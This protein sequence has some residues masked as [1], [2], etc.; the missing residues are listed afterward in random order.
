MVLTSRN[1]HYLISTMYR[2]VAFFL[3][4]AT[5]FFT[6]R[7]TA[8]CASGT[9]SGKIFTDTNRDG[10]DNESGAGVSG[11]TVYLFEPNNNVPFASTQ[12]NALGVY[13]FGA[14]TAAK[15]RVEFGVP[16]FGPGMVVTYAGTQNNTSVT[17]VPPGSCNVNMGVINSALMP[18]NALLEIGN[19]VWIDADKDGVQDADEL[20][21][22]GIKVGLY[23]TAGVKLLETTTNAQG[24]YYF[25]DALIQTF[26]DYYIVFGV[27]Q[28]DKA[29]QVLSNNYMI[30]LANIGNAP[31]LD[32]NDSD[33]SIADNTAPATIQGYPS[34]K[35]KTNN[36]GVTDHSFD[37]GFYSINVATSLAC[38][39]IT[40]GLDI[41]CEAKITPA[42]I[43]T[44]RTDF[45]GITV[46]VATLNG[47]VIPNATV[48][49]GGNYI[50][51]VKD[52]SGNSCWTKLL[53]ED[54]SRPFCENASVTN[55]SCT[56]NVKDLKPIASATTNSF[57][58]AIGKVQESDATVTTFYTGY[59]TFTGAPRRVKVSILPGVTDDIDLVD[60]CGLLYA[61]YTDAI[62]SFDCNNPNGILMELIRTWRLTDISGNVGTNACV[63][64]FRF[65]KTVNDVVLFPPNTS[66]LCTEDVAKR[67]PE[68]TGEPTIGGLKVLAASTA[69][70][71]VTASYK[72]DFLA[73][74]NASIGQIVRHWTV[75]N[76][77]TQKIS[78]A[79]QIITITPP[80]PIAIL[81]DE[82]K[83]T[84]G[85]Q[86]IVGTDAGEC[87]N[88][89]KL[90]NADISGQA[91]GTTI[92]DAYFTIKS[93]NPN[94]PCTNYFALRNLSFPI[95]LRGL[96]AKVPSL[97]VG[98]Y[99]VEVYFTNS[100]GIKSAIQTF[101]LRVNDQ[102]APTP[103]CINQIAVALSDANNGSS[104]VYPSNIDAG[105]RDNCTLKELK[106][107]KNGVDFTDFVTL[108]CSDNNIMLS[109]RAIDCA[110]NTN[111]C[112]VPVTIQDKSAPKCT[113][114]G[115]MTMTCDD[116]FVLKPYLSNQDAGVVQLKKIAGA[117]T[118]I[119]SCTGTAYETFTTN[120]NTCGE[121]TLT[122]MYKIAK[123][124]IAP[125][126]CTQTITFIS[127][128]KQNFV[129]NFPKD[130]TKNAC[131][132]DLNTTG[133]P[134]IDSTLACENI[135]V[136]YTDE[137][138]SDKNL[139]PNGNTEFCKKVIRTWKVINMCIYNPTLQSYLPQGDADCAYDDRTAAQPAG[140]VYVSDYSLTAAAG[141]SGN[142]LDPSCSLSNTPLSG[143]APNKIFGKRARMLYL[144]RASDDRL[145]VRD[146]AG[147]GI[148]RY[149]QI[150]NIIDNE[151]PKFADCP[152]DIVPASV[153]KVL[154]NCKSTVQMTAPNASDNCTAV[155]DIKYAYTIKPFDTKDETLWQKGAGNTF[156]L[157]LPNTLK[158]TDYHVVNWSAEDR[159]GNISTCSTKFSMV[160]TKAPTILCR[161]MYV[162]LMEDST[163]TLDVSKFVLSSTD[164][165]SIASDLSY[166]FDVTTKQKTKT[167]NCRDV[168]VTSL[169]PVR[170]YISDK[171]GNST[172]CAT[173]IIFRNADRYNCG[174]L[175][176]MI[177]GGVQ[178][179]DL[180]GIQGVKVMINTTSSVATALETKL[181]GTF[182]AELLASKDYTVTPEKNNDL[183][184][185]ISTYDLLMI[186][187]HIL[188]VEKLQSPYKVIAAD[189]NK[190]GN[191][192][193]RD[194]LELRKAVL[195]IA[196][197]FPNNTSW[198]FV[199]RNYDFKN[200]NDAASEAFPES[201]NILNLKA[202]QHADFI[203][204]KIGDVN[205]SNKDGLVS[206]EERGARNT[207]IFNT[208][209]ATIKA[210][211]E[212]KITFNTDKTEVE[213]F[214][215][216][217]NFDKNAL[218][219]VTINGDN[220]AMTSENIGLLDGAL[221]ASW[222]GKAVTGKLF[223][224]TFR[225]KTDG[226]LSEFINLNNRYTEA[227]AYTL[228]GETM[229]L[230]LKF[231]HQDQNFALYQNQPNPFDKET[232]INFHL[233]QAQSATLTVYDVTG[234]IV[235]FMGGSYEKGDNQLKIT[236]QDL[237][238]SGVFYY[239]L[240]TQ[241][242]T[243]TKRMVM[244]K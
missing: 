230:A 190:D 218:D 88:S 30:T 142:A 68:Y 82:D 153:Q 226:Q 20:P 152:K 202:Q 136:T 27:G 242:F 109:L 194:V 208:N 127:A 181:A 225:A 83:I 222:A 148:I 173:N 6:H 232:T 87:S 105:S 174:L 89:G 203:G 236:V 210:G 31:N 137:V 97:Y 200:M 53:V 162:E 85:I 214:Q 139:S 177:M 165:C 195:R 61:E 122:R 164:N 54:K 228:A 63:Q 133:K 50:V 240:A 235:K 197:N 191:V 25:M 19:F 183:L 129:V 198:R 84:T 157:S 229:G 231:N 144:T 4:F 43:L 114:P 160:D 71:R 168:K 201:F 179:E 130:V 189:V 62:T 69:Y 72:D 15:Y 64:T 48:I 36:Y 86:R 161:D 119:A 134:Q 205:I 220:A 212:V 117:F 32:L 192:T 241:G 204:V 141:L 90:L 149:V 16:T 110:E 227:E 123:A 113:A 196:N 24:K 23:T 207:L 95:V 234:K 33:M 135:Q 42:M 91:C 206:A 44:G 17:C 151:T 2:I 67:L 21:L 180:T 46:I 146:L 92:T 60:N 172:Y 102:E 150:I 28:F 175:T 209:N 188:D 76:N 73:G 163:L 74:C 101:T 131:N 186:Q 34:I 171:S 178:T 118:N 3:V 244:M 158:T 138:F 103:I 79:D 77:C 121:G 65:L 156:T 140:N 100:C 57:G 224:M 145:R 49:K 26:T 169:V 116:W 132:L 56:T 170:I 35:M 159:C 37:A 233:P 239:T 238:I 99:V 185:G 147:D 29:T 13:T 47:E 128:K 167:W 221:T 111:F 213:G 125:T 176:P 215:Y 223:T 8:Q 199:S 115:D 80:T 41:N 78:I 219:F 193:M 58:L 59:Y 155:A 38:H 12:T 182:S 184:N 55:V 126:T 166:G 237:P 18:A 187:K 81:T 5:P 10:I 124:G 143:I 217:L 104:R 51:E 94:Y 112:M 14:L 11:I 154:D 7:A 211:E 39:P 66:L 120:V 93:F 40:T 107:S 75:M 52:A 70:C 108:T 106:I 22:P 1:N 45:T 96:D 9:I 216:T 243:A 98:E